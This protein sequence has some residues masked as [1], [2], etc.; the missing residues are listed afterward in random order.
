MKHKWQMTAWRAISLA[1]A[2]FM[3]GIAG[4]YTMDGPTYK[5]D[6]SATWQTSEIQQ[7]DTHPSQQRH[8]LSERDSV[9]KRVSRSQLGKVLLQAIFPEK[10]IRLK[11]H[12]HNAQNL[13]TYQHQQFRVQYHFGLVYLGSHM[14]VRTFGD[15]IGL[16]MGTDKTSDES[17]ILK[18]GIK[19]RW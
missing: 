9:Q 3:P 7:Y 6:F 12:S 18:L 17:R 8:S 19:V 15:S 13:S 16:S 11:K 4:A 14:K 2:C 5:Q 1:T 10:I